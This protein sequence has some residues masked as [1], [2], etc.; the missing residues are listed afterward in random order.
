LLDLI[1]AEIALRDG[2]LERASTLGRAAGV[3][4]PVGHA[5]K[6]RA[7]IIAGSAERL[8]W[9]L[10]SALET[11]ALAKTVSTRSRDIGEASWG[12]CLSAIFL[13]D[14]RLR[15]VV[16]E[17]SALGD[18][19]GEDR[20]RLLIARQNLA[21]L[22]EGLYDLRRDEAVAHALLPTISDPLVRSGWGNSHGYMLVL[23]GR[24][25]HAKSVLAP[26][27]IDLDRYALGFARPHIEWSMAAAELGLRQ[28]ARADFLL[29]RVEQYVGE[30]GSPYL[31]LNARALRA[32]LLLT[33]RR[34]E[35][36]AEVTGEAFEDVP[37]N[38][39]YGE[40]VATPALALAA[41]GKLDSAVATAARAVTF[42]QAVETRVLAAAAIA[43][44][45]QG[46]PNIEPTARALFDLAAQ[47]RAWD[48]VVVAIRAV[49]TLL[50]DLALSATH[51]VQLA[52]V[53]ARSNDR[54][55]ARS[56]GLGDGHGYRAQGSLSPRESE[57]I[58]LLGQGL[59]TR[60]IAGALYISEATV[61]AHVSHILEKLGARTRAEAVARYT[62]T[63]ARAGASTT[64]ESPSPSSSR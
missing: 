58:D 37:R 36:A 23:Q 21:R 2:L 31:H 4:L 45:S 54:A 64:M 42:T 24:Y 48:G 56:C 13:E 49:P 34:A 47:L 32:R 16:N 18:T 14:E 41:A 38:A 33:Q 15:D 29:R 11:F 59:K 61:K 35:E 26:V 40:Y 10:D 27:L 63:S 25:A 46:T 9:K 7:F 1:D 20:I 44:A 12:R 50:T 57:V 17:Y 52:R 43:V 5:L 28:F 22:S 51:R 30:S 3:L 53:L 8:D 6:A 39:M 62:E 60:D 19:S 55:L